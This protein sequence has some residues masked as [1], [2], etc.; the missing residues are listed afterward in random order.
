MTKKL[1]NRTSKAAKLP[2][3]EL[4]KP[5]F[6]P[7]WTLFDE[8]QDDP[9]ERAEKE[10]AEK[11]DLLLDRYQIPR[12]L[13]PAAKWYRLSMC[14]A[15]E[16]ERGFKIVYEKQ[17]ELGRGRPRRWDVD[18]QL[19]LVVRVREIRKRKKLNVA[20]ACRH[21]TIDGPYSEF[22]DKPESLETR[23]RE[24]V[25]EIRRRA[26][27]FREAPFELESPPQQKCIKKS[28]EN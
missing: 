12:N 24:A 8:A 22:K 5:I 17:T 20:K 10:R 21:L 27:H 16:H 26:K 1:A 2:P 3:G 15:C 4:S 11:L 18:A 13:D 9:M 7:V 25:R 23:Y 6:V 14:L 28:D 19:E